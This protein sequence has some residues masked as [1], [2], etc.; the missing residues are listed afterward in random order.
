MCWSLNF[1]L[2]KSGFQLSVECSQFCLIRVAF[3]F[4]LLI[5]CDWLKK[6][7]RP[8]LNQSEVRPKPTVS[9]SHTF[10]RALRHLHVFASTLIGSF[11]SLCLFVIGQSNCFGFGFTTLV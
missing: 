3:G 2:D 1:A 11:C 5:F 6:N 9:L 10:S 7:L 4:S 8:F